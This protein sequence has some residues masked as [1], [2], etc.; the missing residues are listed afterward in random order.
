[1]NNDLILS[2]HE[3]YTSQDRI[4]QSQRAGAGQR[5]SNLLFYEKLSRAVKGRVPVSADLIV[6]KLTKVYS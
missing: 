2:C 5:L 6:V 1:M 3:Q 4:K